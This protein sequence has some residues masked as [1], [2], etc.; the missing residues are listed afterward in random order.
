MTKNDALIALYENTK[1]QAKDCENDFVHMIEGQIVD[2]KG[3]VFDLMSADCEDWHEYIPKAS[4]ATMTKEKA[5]LALYMEKLKIKASDWTNKFIEL[6]SEGK[7]IDNKGNSFDFQGST[8]DEWYEW[9]EPTKEDDENNISGVENKVDELILLVQSLVSNQTMEKNTKVTNSTNE[10]IEAVYGVKNPSEVKTLFSQSLTDAKS[11]FDVQKAIVQVIPYCWIDKALT[12]TSKYYG[13][14][15]NIVKEIGGEFEELALSL[16]L[17]PAR[18]VTRKENGSEIKV[19]VGLYESLNTH[20][21]DRTLANIDNKD[22]YDLDIINKAKT[23]LRDMID[24]NEFKK[25]RQT[26][27]ERAKAYV[28]ASYLAI[29]TPRRQIEIL[30]T[31][32]LIQEDGIWYF[33]GLAKKGKE[34]TKIIAY[35]LDDDFELLQKMLEY[36][37]SHILKEL[38]G[39]KVTK[40]T[41]ASKFNG[42]FNNSL[43]AFTDTN[44]TYKDMREISADI[45]WIE[46]CK[47]KDKNECGQIKEEEFKSMV[48]GHATPKGSLRA[49]LHYMTKKGK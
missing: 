33:T 40:T 22:T 30:F 34:D 21:T 5:I 12:T 28:Y 18:T 44:F 25:E 6:D 42:S 39:K 8:C 23:S 37:Q 26:S 3:N 46:N 43:K 29:V 10:K 45:L 32:K 11:V 47:D 9:I 48:L 13:E 14:L 17:P 20:Y 36:V 41:I 24:N 16:L 7:T 1:I 15:R 35:S 19:T 27:D 4:I 2:D 38:E 49:T 31:S